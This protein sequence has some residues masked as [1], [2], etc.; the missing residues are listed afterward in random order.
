MC[1]GPHPSRY[2]PKLGSLSTIIEQEEANSHEDMG[3]LGSLQLL[4][5]LKTTPTSKGVSKGLMYVDVNINGR[6]TQAMVDTGAT[7]NFVSEE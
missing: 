7:H 4:N 6:A 3:V 5:A 2:Y 1:K